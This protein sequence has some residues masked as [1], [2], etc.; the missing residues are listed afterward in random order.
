MKYL[1]SIFLALVFLNIF[2]WYWIIVGAP[3]SAL[4][5]YFLDVGQGDG[6]LVVLP[7]GPKILIDGGPDKSVL[8]ELDKILSP[9]DRYID[10]V[11]LS[12]SQLDHFAGFIPALERYRVGAFL[13]N[14]R[15]GE[16]S[17]WR[18]L[19]NVLEDKEIPIIVL[20]AGDSIIYKGNKIAI[21]SPDGKLINDAELNNTTLVAELESNG[22]KTLFTGDIGFEV[23][24]YLT[25]KY[26]LNVD[27]LKVPHHGSKYSS[28]TNFLNEA[29]PLISIIE[30]GKNKYGHPTTSA[31][32]R[33]TRVGS[34][35]YRTDDKGAIHVKVKNNLINVLM[36]NQ[37]N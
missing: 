2:V 22:V 37:N 12:H 11:M 26:D 34:S 21:L 23:E 35:I 4:N 31:I 29:T 13:W 19:K 32:E 17:A 8:N 14:G 25:N 28:G 30:V 9:T 24:N 7:G 16:I 1:S 36:E 6:N 15:A 3:S 20:G 33:L 27:V 10:L 5:M 18:E